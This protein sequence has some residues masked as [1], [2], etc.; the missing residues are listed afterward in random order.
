MRY[1]FLFSGL[2]FWITTASMAQ[3]L[4]SRRTIR[5]QVVDARTGEPLPYTT[6]TGVARIRFMVQS[7]VDGYFTL[8][9]IRTTDTLKL[10]VS[11]LGYTPVQIYIPPSANSLPE[12]LQIV[13]EPSS[14]ELR[15][16]EVKS[17]DAVGIS[18]Q[19][20]AGYIRFN[21]ALVSK[22]PSFGERDV[23]RSLQLLPGVSA[24]QESSA[25]LYVR[26]GTP[27]QTLILYDGF[28]VYHVDHLNGFFSAFNA[29]A[30]KDVQL[31]RGGFPARFGG[32]ASAIADITSKNGNQK[33]LNVGGEMGLISGSAFL[34]GPIG[35]KITFLVTGR[36]SWQS[37]IYS[38]ILQKFFSN[39][40]NQPSSSSSGTVQ[41][42][43][44]GTQSASIDQT[45]NFAQSLFYDINAK[46]VYRPT[47]KDILA[48]SLYQGYDLMDNSFQDD[49][50][51][52][53]PLPGEDEVNPNL[54][55]STKDVS[56]WGNTGASFKWSRQLSK[57]LYSNALISYSSYFN[58]R[59]FFII[60]SQDSTQTQKEGNVEQNTI[61]DFAAKWDMTW[62]PNVR[63][64]VEWGTF[65]TQQDVS[66]E[67]TQNET[68]EL[69]NKRQK[70]L[71][72][73][74]YFQ[75]KWQIGTWEIQPGIRVNYYS[76]TKKI[77]TEPRLSIQGTI[78]PH[79]QVK[80][81]AGVYHQFIK[82]IIREDIFAGNR[83]FWLLAEGSELPVIRSIHQIIGFYYAKKSFQASVELYAKQN[84]GITEYSLRFSPTTNENLTLQETFFNGNEQSK[85]IDV[86]LQQK[87]GKW[88]GWMGYSL[89]DVQREI[90][91]FSANP[92]PADHDVRHQ[93]KII[94]L[95]ELKKF[96]FSAS[97]FYSS[98]RP[99]TSI[100]GTYS[101][102]LLDGTQ[103][104]FLLPSA[105]NGNRF[106]DYH[107][108]D[109]SASYHFSSRWSVNLT[110][111]NAYNRRNTWYK[112]YNID[113]MNQRTV[114]TTTVHFLPFTPTLR[115][116]WKLHPY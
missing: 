84:T 102:K 32:R 57:S 47:S 75:D 96:D 103:K 30:L 55:F 51:N 70:A 69:T 110:V 9:N 24:A 68:I 80:G 73:V 86:L 72:W 50:S 114:Q 98:G 52:Y 22:L 64:Q 88:S 33:Q 95:V 19:G 82:P 105:K 109:V 99:F 78:S 34:E 77:Y 107:R 39:S 59:D 108:L 26:G 5:G 43:P 53:L 66:Y 113:P 11:Y 4:E 3:E 13:M 65:L 116:N 15:E 31:Y 56:R 58:N 48:L 44:D 28:T 115:I 63:H 81:A 23:L 25:G 89:A 100:D 40:G 87:I 29:H 17:Q 10:N 18:S 90:T 92:Y 83:P 41:V 54:L 104:T 111:F 45:T 20:S 101:L 112:R 37:P 1:F 67:F 2:F 49:A 97:W 14:T 6:I 8:T 36:R 106:P 76:P 27:D 42:N 46:V 91:A 38:S 93:W 12:D 35:K 7:N 71:T 62:S 61:R 60:S 74:G 79:L 85:G 21:T 16:I 94:Q